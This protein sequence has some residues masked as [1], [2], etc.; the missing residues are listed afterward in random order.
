MAWLEKGTEHV[1]LAGVWGAH[2][3][4]LLDLC[5]QGLKWAGLYSEPLGAEPTAMV[6]D[7]LCQ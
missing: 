7:Q 4:P 1:Q 3:S 2:S 5:I 6:S